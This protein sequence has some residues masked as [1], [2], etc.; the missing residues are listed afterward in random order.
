[1]TGPHSPGSLLKPESPEAI[2]PPAWSAARGVTWLAAAA[3]L[4]RG[5][6]LPA[7]HELLLAVW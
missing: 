5:R 1:M 4:D 2:C 3:G 6:R 7:L